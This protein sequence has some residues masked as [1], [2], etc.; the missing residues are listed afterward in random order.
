MF[1]QVYL[2]HFSRISNDYAVSNIPKLGCSTVSLQTL[3]YFRNIKLDYFRKNYEF[4]HLC[5]FVHKPDGAVFDTARCYNVNLSTKH[6]D[7]KLV[8]LYRDPLERFIS[9]FRTYNQFSS[10][11]KS[12]QEVLKLL[13]EGLD[14][15]DQHF[16]PQSIFYNPDNI[17]LFVELKDYE[18]FCE[19]NNI[20]WLMVNKTSKTAQPINL[21]EK[22]VNKIKSLYQSDYDLIDKIKASGKIWNCLSSVE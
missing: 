18:K 2:N 1:K 12:V 21:T 5:K 11:K 3:K 20:E 9:A 14:K 13:E 19:K 15:L 22:E 6:P 8:A 4:T 16:Y 7:L 17:D 10:K